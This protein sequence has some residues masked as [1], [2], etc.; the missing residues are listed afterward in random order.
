MN[1]S[2]KKAPSEEGRIL[3]ETLRMAV[4]QIL[5]KKKRLGQYALIWK[6][7]KPVAM[8]D[9]APLEFNNRK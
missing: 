4:S 9:D 8:G 7:G 6:D 3:L 1:A 5:D 2:L